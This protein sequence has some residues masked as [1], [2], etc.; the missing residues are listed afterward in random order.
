MGGGE[1]GGDFCVVSSSGLKV[2]LL[3]NFRR[4]D[5]GC[6]KQASGVNIVS[7]VCCHGNGIMSQLDE[8]LGKM[9]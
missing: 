1:T 9:L 6:S 5:G 4:K 8:A 3:V 2:H 7:R